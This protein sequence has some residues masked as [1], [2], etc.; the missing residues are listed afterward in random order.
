[1][2]RPV[3]LVREL[4]KIYEEYTRGTIEELVAYL[5]EKSSRGSALLIVEE[6]VSYGSQI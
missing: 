2:N 1:M 4:T 6:P 3:V 5:E